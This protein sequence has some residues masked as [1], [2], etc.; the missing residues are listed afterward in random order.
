MP[1]YYCPKGTSYDIRLRLGSAEMVGNAGLLLDYR[2]ISGK[3]RAIRERWSRCPLELLLGVFTQSLPAIW[4]NTVMVIS[5]FIVMHKLK[6]SS[7]K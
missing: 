4:H 6:K 5:L 7:P 3:T 1:F 2:V